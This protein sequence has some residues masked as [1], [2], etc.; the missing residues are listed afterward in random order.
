VTLRL[1]YRIYYTLD[2][3]ITEHRPET[4]ERIVIVWLFIR[5]SVTKLAR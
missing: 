2:T 1:S 3:F 4:P 5:A